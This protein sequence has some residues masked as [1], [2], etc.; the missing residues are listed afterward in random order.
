MPGLEIIILSEGTHTVAQLHFEGQAVATGHAKRKLGDQFDPELGTYL[1]LA[2]AF[3]KASEVYADKAKFLLDPPSPEEQF[4][5]LPE[6]LR[7]MLGLPNRQEEEAIAKM[8]VVTRADK[9][10]QKNDK[11]REA[12]IA[13]ARKNL[14]YD[15]F[16]E[17][18]EVLAKWLLE[19]FGDLG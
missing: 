7:S 1:A 8:N 6:E 10:A 17:F 13:W 18:D 12:R 5:E 11:R 2:R 16:E 19:K 15:E 3:S 9:R 4:A 14:A